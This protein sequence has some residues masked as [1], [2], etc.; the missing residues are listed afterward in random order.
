MKTDSRNKSI[1]SVESG[2]LGVLTYSLD[3]AIIG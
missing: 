2:S 1:H 3:G